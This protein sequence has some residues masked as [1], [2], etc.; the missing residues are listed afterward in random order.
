M[1]SPSSWTIVG[2]G[3]ASASTMT[4]ASVADTGDEDAEAEAE[5]SQ[6][7]A[8]A[9]KFLEDVQTA[10]II[11]S[12]GL[13]QDDDDS[14][15]EDGDYLTATDSTRGNSIRSKSPATSG[16]RGACQKLYN[17]NS[18]SKKILLSMAISIGSFGDL[19]MEPYKS[20]VNRKSFTPTADNLKDEISRRA[21]F[22]KLDKKPRPKG[23]NTARLIQWLV[24][25][26]ITEVDDIE[27]ITREVSDFESKLVAAANERSS[28]AE[29]HRG[30]EAWLGAEPFLRLYHVMMDDKVREAYTNLNN[31]LNRAELDARNSEARPPDFY[32]LACNL[33]NDN[34]FNP[35]THV[36]PDLHEDF[37]SPIKLLFKDAPTP[38]TPQKIKEKIADIRARLVVIIDKWERSGNGGGNR[39]IDDDDYGRISSMTLQDDDRANFLGGNKP[40]LLYFWQILDECELLQRTL[41][42]IPKEHSASSDGIPSTS[43]STTGSNRKKPRD[44]DDEDTKN[45][46][47]KIEASFSDIASSSRVVADSTF[48]SSRVVA[49]STVQKQYKEAADWY[50]D[51]HRQY[52]A[53]PDGPHKLKLKE[54]MED[55]EKMYQVA[56]EKAQ[57]A[58]DK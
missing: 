43:S 19:S 35:E 49:D 4:G 23:W 21:A 26:P 12:V 10:T 29:L 33:F 47:R 32:D 39:S 2:L 31:V 6:D 24:G 56:K 36:Y 25:N 38:A 13:G 45:F 55:A 16:R 30:V 1:T 27:F 51:L 41:S 5:Y 44:D 48:L 37:K 3:R 15:D 52:S 50:L 40:H 17:D 9:E 57:Q 22:F 53:E 58:N 8:D 46:Q 18:N 11:H 20:A 28:E 7:I 42:I 14:I 54:I 34:Q